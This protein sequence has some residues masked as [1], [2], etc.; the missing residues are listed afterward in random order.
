MTRGQ[1]VTRNLLRNRRRTL[2][3]TASVAVSICLLACFFATYRY[4]QAPP[5]PGGFDRVLMVGS[6]TSLMASL[7]LQY[8]ERISR[9]PGVAA[10]TP[11]NMV[12]ALYGSQDTLVFALACDPDAIFQVRDD[13]QLPKD[14]RRAFREEKTALVCSRSAAAKHGWKL[15]DH[16]QLRSS[17]YHLT[18]DLV[19]RGIYVSND[20]ESLMALHWDYLNEVQGRPNRPGAFWVQAQATED[21][22][23]LMQTIDGQFRNSDVETRTQPMRQF[24]LDMLSMLGNLKLILLGISGAVVFAVLLIVSNSMGM[25]IRERTAELAVLRALGFRTGQ[26]LGMLTAE[27]LAIAVAGAA[28]GCAVAALLLSLASGYR[29]AGAM[30]IYVQVDVLTVV[31]GFVTAAAVGLVSTLLPA[32]RASRIEIAQALRS[33]G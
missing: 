23:R 2:L 29:V 7:P 24:I 11:I 16:I 19:L 4:L 21:V 9:L 8:A 5:A 18:L 10:V 28:A 25:S 30:P 13:W 20:D 33:V 6:R 14:Q 17:G 26:V 3:T 22:S 32:Y 27:A 15:G 1:F 12:D 31:A